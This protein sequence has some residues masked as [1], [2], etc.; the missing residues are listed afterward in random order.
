[1]YKSISPSLSTSANAEDVLP[2]FSNF[3]AKTDS[4]NLPFPSLKKILFGPPN[5]VTTKSKS[6]SPSTSAKTDPLE[7]RFGQETPASFVTSLNS[8]FPI[9]IY[10]M[11]FSF[12]LGIYI[13]TH[14]SLLISPRAIPE[15]CIKCW[16][17]RIS[18]LPISF[19]AVMPVVFGSISVKPIVSI[20]DNSGSDFIVKNCGVLI[21]TPL[22]LLQ[23]II[24]K[25]KI[26]M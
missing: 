21:L 11:L 4:E 15:P 26:I 14:P 2:G 24:N 23:L 3:E 20:I 17:A 6:L 16:F 12:N 25:V 1:M 18:F 9:F 10:N 22:F 8:Q 5:A 19:T 7:Y 13:S